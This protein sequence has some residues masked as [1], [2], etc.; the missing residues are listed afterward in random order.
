MSQGSDRGFFHFLG[1][2]R[3]K[4]TRHNS[5][6]SHSQFVADSKSAIFGKNLG[7]AATLSQNYQPSLPKFSARNRLVLPELTSLGID[8]LT[9]LI[10]YPKSNQ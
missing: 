5:G 7:F 2:R 1:D 4:L 9:E 6:N 8:V 10:A 3:T